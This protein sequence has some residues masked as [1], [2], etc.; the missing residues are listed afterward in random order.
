MATSVVGEARL[1]RR[2]RNLL[3]NA[4]MRATRVEVRHVLFKHRSRVRVAN[5]DDGVEK[6]HAVHRIHS[7]VHVDDHATIG[8][9]TR[10]TVVY[11]L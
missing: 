7:L 8:D 3:L 10:F 9:K 4:L 1:A 6:G 5:N 11:H 2:N